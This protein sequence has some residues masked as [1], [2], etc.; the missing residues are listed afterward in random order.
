MSTDHPCYHFR[1]A[2]LKLLRVVW[3][4]IEAFIQWLTR[5]IDLCGTTS[6]REFA[7]STTYRIITTAIY[8]REFNF[9][10]SGQR[11]MKCSQQQAQIADIE[12]WELNNAAR[13]RKIYTFFKLLLWNCFLICGVVEWITFKWRFGTEKIYSFLWSFSWCS[14]SMGYVMFFSMCFTFSIVLSYCTLFQNHR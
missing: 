10:L 3:I 5:Q 11:E 9:V 2:S 14:N 7:A 6:V 13:G 12:N 4:H 8:L 1:K